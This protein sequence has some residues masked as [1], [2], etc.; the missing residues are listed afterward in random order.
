MR[1]SAAVG[2][3]WLLLGCAGSGPGPTVMIASAPGAL[4]I[5]PYS[6]TVSGAPWPGIVPP[7]PGAPAVDGT[8]AGE[9][10]PLSTGG[11][12]CFQAR[13]ITGFHVQGGRV[14]FDGFTGAIDG[15]NAVAMSY[16]TQRLVGRFDADL[17]QGQL[18][19]TGAQQDYGCVF[20]VTLR[21]VGA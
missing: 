3:C 18:V 7:P 1:G 21:R 17:F 16:G 9:A 19:T 2:L 4:A 15:A 20:A 6:G 8:Y 5:S 12:M 11:G 13:R 10:N 14:R